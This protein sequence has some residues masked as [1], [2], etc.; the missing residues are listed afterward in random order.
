MVQQK[1][2]GSEKKPSS[3]NDSGTAS[4]LTLDQIL[5][6]IDNMDAKE[7]LKSKL[8][9][10][11]AETE[12][13]VRE[14][15]G[16]VHQSETREEKPAGK[17]WSVIGG[18]PIEDPDGPYSTF[19]QAYAVADLERKEENKEG[20][21]LQLLISSGLIGGKNNNDHFQIEMNKLMFS[22]IT[23]MMATPKNDQSN[24]MLQALQTKIKTLEEEAVNSKD[25]VSAA[26]RLAE[27]V[28]ALR[29]IGMVPSGPS[30]SVSVE[31]LREENRHDEELR[32]IGAEAELKSSL[33]R[34]AESI[35]VAIGEGI[36]AAMSVGRKGKPPAAAPNV[37]CPRCSTGFYVPGDVAVVKCPKCG[38]ELERPPNQPPRT[39]PL[40]PE[41]DE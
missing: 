20:S 17:R 9:L 10:M 16:R 24:T 12:A 26:R 23:T 28:G 33:G 4:E 29:E 38:A 39:V 41:E 2:T 27:T 35:P 8:R 34:A 11:R 18:K 37:V 14:L 6:K 21:M 5:D 19:A 15:E 22:L 13:R 25:P 30:E 7:T 36:G 3:K 32:K 40:V 1:L 31:K